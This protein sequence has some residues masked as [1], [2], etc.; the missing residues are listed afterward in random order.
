[1]IVI[2]VSVFA[3]SSNNIALNNF[4][5]CIECCANNPVYGKLN[6]F[7]N[8]AEYKAYHKAYQQC[9][10]NIIKKEYISEMHESVVTIEDTYKITPC[11]GFFNNYEARESKRTMR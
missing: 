5:I 3:K 2:G 9:Y 10:D 6:T 11:K 1:M 4:V 8:L 7:T